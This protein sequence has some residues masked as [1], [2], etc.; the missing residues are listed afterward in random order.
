M[1]DNIEKLIIQSR[2]TIEIPSRAEFSSLMSN[3]T[4]KS[5]NRN[6]LQ[7]GI[8]SPFITIMNITKNRL[9]V[10]GSVALLAIIVIIPTVRHQRM[11]IVP[12]QNIQQET[13]SLDDQSAAL[14]QESKGTVSE[15]VIADI[16]AEF[17]QEDAIIA[18]ELSEDGYVEEDYDS[19]S[20]IIG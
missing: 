5:F 11:V 9:I 19:I 1:Q 12:E 16:M 3:V 4:K 14:I 13:M 6:T 15:D 8:K 7:K 20:A 18:Q 10:A 17:S 2:D